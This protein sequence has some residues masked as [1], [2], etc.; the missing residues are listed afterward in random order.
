MVLGYL[1]V[2]TRDC[3]YFIIDD[4]HPVREERFVSGIFLLSFHSTEKELILLPCN[5]RKPRAFLAKL[6]IKVLSSEK[7]ASESQ[8][9]GHYLSLRSWCA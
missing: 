4:I 1:C 9:V 8:N 5:M 6:I 2:L 7:N 3:P